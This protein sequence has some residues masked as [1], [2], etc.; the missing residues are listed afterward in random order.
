VSVIEVLGDRPINDYA[1]SEAG[2][3]R[4]L[5]SQHHPHA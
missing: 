4:A 3:P 5:S 2:K 1:S